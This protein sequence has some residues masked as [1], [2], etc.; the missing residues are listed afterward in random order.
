[1]PQKCLSTSP[2]S[3]LAR[4]K[5]PRNV[6]CAPQIVIHTRMAE[7]SQAQDCKRRLVESKTHI[8]LYLCRVQ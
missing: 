6:N 3:A 5:M 7:L 2:I 4:A 1:M 8:L